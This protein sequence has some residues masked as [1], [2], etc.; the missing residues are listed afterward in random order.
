LLRFARQMQSAS[1]DMFL[2]HLVA[3]SRSVF[4]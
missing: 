1:A 4:M 3:S 2:M